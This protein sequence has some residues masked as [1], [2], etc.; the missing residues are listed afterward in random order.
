MLLLKALQFAAERHDGQ[1]RKVT[2]LPYV[3][4]PTTVAFLLQEHKTSKRI[5]ELMAACL[6]HDTVEDTD[7]TIEEL[8]REF[9]PLVAQLVAELT[10]DPEEIKEIG[11]TPYL[12]KKMAAMSKYALTIKL[13]DRLSNVMDAPT[14]SYKE[15][16]RVI[17]KYLEDNRI[18]TASQ[19]RL[20]EVIRQHVAPAQEESEVAGNVASNVVSA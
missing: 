8:A 16:T 10:S 19:V 18:L 14:E 11:K 12:C 6:L 20:I 2:G 1:V 15:S 17:L 9:T 13:A 5:E 4:H 7:T 3:V